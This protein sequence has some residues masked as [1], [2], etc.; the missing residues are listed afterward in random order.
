MRICF[1]SG[2]CANG[3]HSNPRQW[4]KS[5][6]VFTYPYNLPDDYAGLQNAEKASVRNPSRRKR[7]G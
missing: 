6:Q 4:T 3:G 2:S 5:A 7:K 1:S